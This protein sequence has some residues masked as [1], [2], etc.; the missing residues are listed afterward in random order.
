M[1]SMLQILSNFF[2]L[3]IFYNIAKNV[4]PLTC[5]GL[6]YQSKSL[7][8]SYGVKLYFYFCLVV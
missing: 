2:F 7:V 4:Y 5:Q 6:S 1:L 8:Q 3:W